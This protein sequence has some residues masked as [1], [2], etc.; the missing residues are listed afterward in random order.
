[1]A[2]GDHRSIFQHCGY[3]TGQYGGTHRG[4]NVVTIYMLI[5]SSN[6]RADFI[7]IN[8]HTRL[9]VIRLILYH[10][11]L[12]QASFTRRNAISLSTHLVKELFDCAICASPHSVILIQNVS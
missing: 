7:E 2:Y 10:R 9:Q 5:I 6:S 1:M 12:Q 4:K 3:K 11:L 8:V